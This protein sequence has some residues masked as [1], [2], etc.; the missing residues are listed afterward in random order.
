MTDY[1]YLFATMLQ[2]KL[3]CKIRG[4]I[5]VEV[6]WHDELYVKIIYGD[7]KFETRLKNFTE[8]FQHGLTTEYVTYEIVKQYKQVL[9]RQMEEKYF[10]LD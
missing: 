4:R 5:F 6:N 7:E 3:K 8:K 1:E 10:Y 9:Y 2:Q